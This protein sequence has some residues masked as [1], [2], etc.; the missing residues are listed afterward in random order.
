MRRRVEIEGKVAEV[1]GVVWVFCF[2]LVDGAGEAGVANVAPG[3]NYV[4][5]YEDGVVGHFGVCAA[6]REM[7]LCDDF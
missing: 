4:A 3:A 5:G 1:E 2:V 7:V 6:G